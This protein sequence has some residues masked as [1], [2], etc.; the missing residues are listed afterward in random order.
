MYIPEAQQGLVPEATPL[1]VGAELALPYPA[2][3]SQPYPGGSHARNHRTAG[4]L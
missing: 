1:P 4:S 3:R 2:L